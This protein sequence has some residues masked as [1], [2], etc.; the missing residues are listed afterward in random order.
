MNLRNH[1]IL[2]MKLFVPRKRHQK[3][4]A[5]NEFQQSLEQNNQPINQRGVYTVL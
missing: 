2:M 4:D 1:N 3:N 5:K